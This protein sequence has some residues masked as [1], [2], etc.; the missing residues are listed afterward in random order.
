MFI[1]GR[2]QNEEQHIIQGH[3]LECLSDTSSDFIS[4][5]NKGRHSNRKTGFNVVIAQNVRIID[6]VS[7]AN[8]FN[9]GFRLNLVWKGTEAVRR[10]SFWLASFQI[11]LHEAQ[12]QFN[13]NFHIP[14]L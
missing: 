1:F 3:G 8:P 10:I 13:A 11:P 14:L 5:R 6:Y 2:C 7:P 4:V 12:T 9:K